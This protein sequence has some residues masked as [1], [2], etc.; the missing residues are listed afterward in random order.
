MQ[1]NLHDEVQSLQDNTYDIPEEVPVRNARASEVDRAIDGAVDAVAG[2]SESITSPSVFDTFRSMLKGASH[3][4]PSQL[5]KVLDA[6]SSAFQSELEATAR[7]GHD[8]SDSTAYRSHRQVL[9]M[10]A[11]LLMWFVQVAEKYVNSGP[12][13]ASGDGDE[14]VPGASKKKVSQVE[15][16][17]LET[18]RTRCTVGL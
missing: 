18:S 11:F 1:F 6:L 3:L 7:D 17:Q 9:E 10:C 15:D 13:G 5:S 14:V 4:S 12:L 16:G 8:L 2:S